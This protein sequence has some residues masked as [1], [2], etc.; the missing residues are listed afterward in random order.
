MRT[1]KAT[2]TVWFLLG[3]ALVLF[4]MAF[5]SHVFGQDL[6][7]N[8]SRLDVNTPVTT[9]P[10]NDGR[11]VDYMNGYLFIDVHDARTVNI[12]IIDWS[13]VA[14]EELYGTTLQTKDG[15]LLLQINIAYKRFTISKRSF[16]ND[17]YI[18]VTNYT[19]PEEQ[20]F[21][22]REIWVK[23]APDEYTVFN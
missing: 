9:M 5:G 13:T 7:D 12:T 15:I 20:E 10:N 11:E 4:M 23:T 16:G 3:M 21:E 19:R 18:F 17:I 22:P 14:I 2:Q 6:A 1:S 8:T